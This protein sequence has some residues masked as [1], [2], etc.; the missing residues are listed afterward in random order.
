MW[1]LSTH[2]VVF[3]QKLPHI[4]TVLKWADQKKVGHYNAYETVVAIGSVLHQGLFTYDPMRVQWSMQLKPYQMPTSGG[5]KRSFNCV[6]ISTDKTF[7]YVGTSA[8]E[9]MIY[10]RDTC[11]FRAIIPVC[12]NG[13]QDIVTLQD[14]TVVGCGG[15]GTLFRLTGKDMTWQKI[16][17]VLNASFLCIH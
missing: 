6:D 4:A 5:I 8:G 12:T 3:S 15:D 13:V 11:V 2:E 7:V 9:L 10:R 16:K 14:D 17:E 1:T